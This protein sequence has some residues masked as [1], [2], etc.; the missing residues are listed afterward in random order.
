M[1]HHDEAPLEPAEPVLQPGH[2]LAV[3]VVGGLVQNQ[4][5][6][7][8]DEGRRQ[9]H[10]LPLAAGEGA[11]LLGEVRDAQPVQHGL[12]LVLVQRPE[13]GGEVEEHLLQHGGGLLHHRVLGQQA[14][15]DVGVAGESARVRLC[16]AGQDF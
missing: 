4:H 15:L 8:V 13:L 2:H 5:V 10:P 12:G 11:H 14:D 7:R 1:G 6:R 16:D 3:Q 9:G